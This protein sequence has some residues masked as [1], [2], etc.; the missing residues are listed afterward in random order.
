MSAAE[1]TRFEDE[2]VTTTNRIYEK[3][4]STIAS[5]EKITAVTINAHSLAEMRDAMV[6][7]INGLG[8]TESKAEMVQILVSDMG[9]YGSAGKT[10]FN[11]PGKDIADDGVGTGLAFILARAMINEDTGVSKDQQMDALNQM[12]KSDEGIKMIKEVTTTMAQKIW[13]PV[14]KTVANA[15]SKADDDK[16]KRMGCSLSKDVVRMVSSYNVTNLLTKTAETIANVK[17]PYKLGAYGIMRAEYVDQLPKRAADVDFMETLTL[18]DLFSRLEEAKK[19]SELAKEKPLPLPPSPTSVLTSLASAKSSDS[20]ICAL[21]VQINKFVE[22]AQGHSFVEL[23]GIAQGY[24]ENKKEMMARH[25]D[26]QRSIADLS[27]TAKAL[28]VAPSVDPATEGNASD[29]VTSK[30]E[31]AFKE[32]E[33]RLLAKLRA[34]KGDRGKGEKPQLPTPQLSTILPT[35]SAD[36]Q[37]IK[38]E[39]KAEGK[40]V[41]YNLGRMGSQAHEAGTARCNNDREK[42]RAGGIRL[43]NTCPKCSKGTS[44]LVKSLEAADK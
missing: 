8:N 10:K 23:E 5:Q 31:D 29:L 28:N 42:L 33:D 36:E 37:K 4:L 22:D 12:S 38:A 20:L 19:E 16:M 1:V 11:I 25:H 40:C 3:C 24:S 43:A 6:L 18:V 34:G 27:S 35:L 14:M 30:L 15:L 7:H 21:Q 41:S 17:K 13:V 9:V 44:Q 26:D 2:N 32:F 39:A